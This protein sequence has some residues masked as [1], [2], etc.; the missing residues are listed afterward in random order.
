M[1]FKERMWAMRV[2]VGLG[3][4]G[5]QYKGTRHNVGF[6][7]IDYLADSHNIDIHK[8]KHK[9]MIGEGMIGQEKVMLVK[10]Q[11]FM[12]LS[13]RSILEILQFY[14][15]KPEQMI[16][17]YDDIDIE[18]GRLRIRTKGSAGT[19]N[20]MKSVLY[21]IQS[22]VFPRIRVGIGKPEYAD[23]IHY[24]MGKFSQEDR[25][26]IDAAIKKAAEAIE[27]IIK[28]GMNMAMNRYNG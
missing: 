11:T 21:E 4:P 1:K 25:E 18:I 10:P 24:V 14:K 20:G 15:I 13:G 16:I 7:V 23:L 12:N 9:A 27:T 8:I 2:I 28:E 17:V 19:H 3:N 5:N 22:D 6:D 26:L